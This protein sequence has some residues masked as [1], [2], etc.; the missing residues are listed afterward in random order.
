[1]S[2]LINYI[3]EISENNI[4]SIFLGSGF[5]IPNIGDEISIHTLS[6]KGDFIV[7]AIKHNIIQL[8]SLSTSCKHNV[9]VYLK[10]VD[11][12]NFK[13]P[14][15][16]EKNIIFNDID[17]ALSLPNCKL[18][19]FLNTLKFKNMSDSEIQ[20]IL[21]QIKP[22]LDNLNIAFTPIFKQN[23]NVYSII[24]SDGTENN[25]D[26]SI[27]EI[28]KLINEGKLITIYSA[29]FLNDKILY[30]YAIIKQ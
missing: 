15:F 13:I 2:T 9:T 11:E 26:I 10:L 17:S 30:T 16:I 22:Y 29:R 6:I 21:N 20:L 18:N 24:G 3:C 25:M 12:N 28:K 27:D 4:E 8:T 23:G 14:P 1:M 19:V 7:E 5:Q